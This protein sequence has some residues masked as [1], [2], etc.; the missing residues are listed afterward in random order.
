[1]LEI[2][3]SQH[4]TEFESR[5]REVRRKRLRSMSVAE[6]WRLFLEMDRLQQTAP[7]TGT[8]RNSVRRREEKAARWKRMRAVFAALDELP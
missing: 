2:V 4:W 7:R 8:V 3:G 6:K 5:M 1:M